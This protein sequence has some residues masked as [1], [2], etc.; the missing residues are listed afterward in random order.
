MATAYVGLLIGNLAFGLVADRVGR[1]TAFTI[2]SAIMAVGLLSITEFWKVIIQA[3]SLE[4]TGMFVTG[5]GA[6][7]FGG[8]G[9]LF[10]ELFPTAVRNSAMGSAYNIA[11]GT[12]FLTPALVAIIAETHGLD[13]GIVLASAFAIATGIY[14]WTFPDTSNRVITEVA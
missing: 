7:M 12:Q 10:T 14:V 1:R 3:E 8:Y 2:F 11:R 5:L 13:G 4:Y 6:G 9:P